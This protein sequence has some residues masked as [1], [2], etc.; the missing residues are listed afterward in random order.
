MNTDKG[1]KLLCFRNNPREKTVQ[2]CTVL[3]VAKHE[4]NGD[5][6][7]FFVYYV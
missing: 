2:E 5:F 6:F 4:N 7:F 3:Y 1:T